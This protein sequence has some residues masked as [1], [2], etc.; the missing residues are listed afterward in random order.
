[1]LARRTDELGYLCVGV[2]ASE[3]VAAIGSRAEHG[4]V[5]ETHGE[6]QILRVAR[7]GREVGQGLVDAAML[8]VEHRL[9]LAVAP[10]VR[11]GFGP[12]RQFAGD[13]QRLPVVAVDV[14]VQQAGEHLV[15]LVPERERRFAAGG[16][17]V[18]KGVQEAGRQLLLAGGEPGHDLVR[19]VADPLVSGAGI[20]LCAGGQIMPDE[21]AARP[22]VGCHPAAIRCGVGRQAGA[23]PEHV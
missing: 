18:G 2:Q 21:L 12:V 1:M 6:L 20:H 3:P 17:R 5:V 13:V 23:E 10:L 22:M 9:Q 15:N 8:D 7:D 11:A 4:Q 16:E 19:P 14:H